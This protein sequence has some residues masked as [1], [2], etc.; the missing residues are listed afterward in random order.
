MNKKMKHIKKKFAFEIPVPKNINDFEKVGRND[1][2]NL[3]AVNQE[4][5]APFIQTTENTLIQS[6]LYDY[7]S[8]KTTTIP[9]PDLTLIYY[10]AAYTFNVKRKDYQQK[11]FKKLKDESEIT[12]GVKNEIYLYFTLATSTIIQM[13]TSMESFLND[14]LPIDYIYIRKTKQKQELF[15]N[16][17]IQGYINF[18]EKILKVIPSFHKKGSFFKKGAFEQSEI[19]KLKNL[20]NEIIHTKSSE[21]REKQAI[22]MTDLFDFEYDKTLLKIREYMNYYRKDYLV[23]CDCEQDY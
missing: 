19:G 11:L 2:R 20:R 18:E 10:D 23:N 16:N 22:L 7:E 15:N 6:F 21:Y 17:Q 13:F 4:K 5:Q 9:I 3:K 1:S 8:E 14:L 12:E